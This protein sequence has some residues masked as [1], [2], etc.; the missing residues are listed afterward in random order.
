MKKQSR[1][2]MAGLLIL[3]LVSTSLA[4]G[5]SSG[6]GASG[7]S[8]SVSKAPS[9]SQT[10]STQPNK[11]ISFRMMMPYWSSALPD[12]SSPLFKK[13]EQI[14]NAQITADFV[15][16]SSYMDKVNVTLASGDL[17]EVLVVLTG[18]QPSI[19]QAIRAGAFWEVGKYVD[20]FPNLKASRSKIS[21][22]AIQ[23]DG[24]V[25]ALY[26]PTDLDRYGINVRQDWLDKVGLKRPR[27]TDE[28]YNVLKAFAQNDPDGNGK[29]DTYGLAS[30]GLPLWSIAEKFGAPNGYKVEGGKFVPAFAT[31]EY[32]NAMKFFRKLFTEGIMNKDFAYAKLSQTDEMLVNG[33]AGVYIGNVDRA[34]LWAKVMKNNA[35]AKLLSFSDMDG[36]N[37]SYAGSGYYNTTMFPKSAVKTEERLLELLGSL[38][39]LAAPENADF[40]V[41]GVEGTDYK[42]ENG[43]K[44]IINNQ[45]PVLASLTTIAATKPEVPLEG[46]PDWHVE[47]YK[48]VA[49]NGKSKTLTPNPTAG[50][51]SQTR[52]EKGNELQKLIDDAVTKYVMNELDDKGFD[53]VIQKWRSTGGDQMLK[54]YEAEHQKLKR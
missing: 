15:Q 51:V 39:R 53:D 36:P 29:N 25:W 10:P 18:N 19:I 28:L 4:A 9:E 22:D 6:N 13:M 46:H 5:C 48:I 43:K 31:E 44:T 20:K 12:A 30:S 32:R 8:P 2:T 42:V 1:K 41:Y 45:W 7:S 16:G 26:K 35:N 40:R 52:N 54:E 24:K 14:M 38:D 3:T 49:E 34:D 17:P 33:Q 21:D 50:L 27:T 11:P 23:V 47:M 37:L